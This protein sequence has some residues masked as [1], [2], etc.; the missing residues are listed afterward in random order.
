V[1]EFARTSL[2][3]DSFASP[4]WRA[5]TDE[6]PKP[7]PD[8]AALDKEL[9]DARTAASEAHEVPARGSQ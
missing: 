4:R 2:P 3:P 1:T 5:V 8:H 6:S 9:L 7:A